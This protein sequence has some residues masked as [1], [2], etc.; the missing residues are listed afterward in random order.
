[1]SV[2]KTYNLCGPSFFYVKVQGEHLGS[3]CVGHGDVWSHYDRYQY[4]FLGFNPVCVYLAQ[5]K[6]F[7][8]V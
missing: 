8:K 4:G 1:M 3:L 7:Q 5:S 6:V 2:Q